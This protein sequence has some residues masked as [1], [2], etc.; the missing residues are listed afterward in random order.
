MQNIEQPRDLER[1]LGGLTLTSVN[2][3]TGSACRV[4]ET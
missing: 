1:A 2:N 4:C 3:C